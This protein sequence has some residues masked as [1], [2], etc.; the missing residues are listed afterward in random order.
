MYDYELYLQIYF[1]VSLIV[2]IVF[3]KMAINIG[4][5][6]DAVSK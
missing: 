6:R 5:I 2:W 3:I 1:V 4:K